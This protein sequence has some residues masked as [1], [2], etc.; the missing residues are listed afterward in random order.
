MDHNLDNEIIA[1][2]ETLAHEHNAT[3]IIAIIEKRKLHSSIIEIMQSQPTQSTRHFNTLFAKN[4]NKLKHFFPKEAQSIKAFHQMITQ[5]I[6]REHNEQ[7]EGN[8][9]FV[10]G[11]PWA[12]HYLQELDAQLRA[13]KYN[14]TAEALSLRFIKQPKEHTGIKHNNIRNK[15]LQQGSGKY[16]TRTAELNAQKHMV[17]MNYALLTNQCGSNTLQYIV[18][19]RCENPPK[20]MLDKIF[21]NHEM[22]IYLKKY[23]QDFDELEMMHREASMF[24]AGIM[25]SFTPEMLQ[26]SVFVCSG[27]GVKRKVQIEGIGETD[28]IKLILDTLRTHPEKI[29]S[30]DHLEFVHVLTKDCALNPKI[31]ESE[32]VKVIPLNA[33]DPEKLALYEQKR[34]ELMAKIKADVQAERAAWTDQQKKEWQIKQKNMQKFYTEFNCMDECYD[35][36]DLVVQED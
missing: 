6:E 19:N 22:S 35:S 3:K 16:Y 26:K 2:F 7:N 5:V 32:A 30:L 29:K 31:I 23:Q 4:L 17:F 14:K 20:L 10:H 9:T 15:L 8:Y 18:N 27:G 13:I 12:F 28:N 33:A 11:H 24:G 34:D 1:Q 36:P 21:E 25:F